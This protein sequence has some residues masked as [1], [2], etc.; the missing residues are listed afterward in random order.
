MAIGLLL[1]FAEA[2]LA[3]DLDVVEAVRQGKALDL[4]ALRRGCAVG[5]ERELDAELLQAVERLMRAREH[6]QFGV[7]EFVEPIGNRVTD[8]AR[9]RRMAARRG[10]LGER[11]ADDMAPRLADAVAPML[12]ACLIRPEIARIGLHRGDDFVGQM[13]DDVVGEVSDDALPLSGRLAEGE[14]DR[15]VEIE[16]DGARQLGHH[17]QA[18]FATRT[19]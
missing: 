10:K 16:Q 18:K 17:G 15:V 1:G 2:V 5:D 19:G 4:G 7:L 8:L 12:V 11:V 14:E 13:G 3:L 6:A 9:R